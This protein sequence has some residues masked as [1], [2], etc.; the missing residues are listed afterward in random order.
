MYKLILL[1]IVTCSFYNCNNKAPTSSTNLVKINWKIDEILTAPKRL[2]K[3]AITIDNQSSVDLNKDNWTLHFSQMGGRP[4]ATSVPKEFTLY[5]KDG[6]FFTLAPTTS[7]ETIPAGASK[8]YQYDITG[9]IDK[10]SEVPVGMFIVVGGK[11][12]EV[13]AT[14]LGMDFET[15]A[16]LQPTTPEI[17]F[18]ENSRL[19]LLNK[20]QLL[21][22]IP[23]PHFYKYLN[24]EKILG[25]IIS[26]VASE[27]LENEISYLKDNLRRLG[28][29]LVKKEENA[30]L[31]I[32]YNVQKDI[33]DEGYRL[34][35][36]KS[37]VNIIGTSQ[38]GIFYGIQSFLQY[39]SYAKLES[40]DK[41]ITLKGID[42]E[43]QPRFDYRGLHLDVARNFH[44]YEDIKKMLD[45]ISFFKVNKFHFHITDDEGW[46][47]EIPG[48]PELTE[49]GSKRGF[50][51]DEK[52]HLIPAYGSGDDPNDSY[53]SGYLTK[54]QFIDILKYAQQR[55]I[56]V[57][58]EIDA[59][60]HSRAAIISMD[61]RFER[62]AKAGNNKAAEE[63][64]LSDPDDESEYGSAQNYHDNVM[65][66]CREGTYNF[67]EKVLSEVVT[68]YKEANVP[69][70]SIHIGGDEIPYGAWQKSPLCNKFIAAN[71]ELQSADD[72][73][74]YFFEKL[75]SLNSK[76]GL[77][78][79]GWEEMVLAHNEDGHNTTE[80]DMTLKDKNVI[81]YVWNSILGGGR[82]DMIYK[83]ANSGF[84]VVMCNSSSFY[85]DMAYDK[86]PA[87]I[88]LSWSG[89]ADT[90][91]AYEAE[92]FNIF[93]RNARKSD[94]TLLT[95]EYISEREK[96]STKGKEN[97]LGIQAQLWS[98]TTRK[99]DDLYYL[100][101]PKILGFVERAW[102][103]PGKWNNETEKSK[104]EAQ[105]L[106][107][108][109]QFANTLGQKTLPMFDTFYP[110]ITYRV[111]PKGEMK[112][113]DQIEEN[114][115]FPGL[116]MTKE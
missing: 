110:H 90:E 112:V 31:T 10:M 36:D 93:F 97:F 16:P 29:D 111:P 86:D 68:M 40:K 5:N 13:D 108:W 3:V 79:A 20:D 25:S 82:E 66:V 99:S 80:I 58:T 88:G 44:S 43:D 101:F 69:F 106:E 6:D 12:Q 100:A 61:Q 38:S 81:P 71:K 4:D 70:N 115:A 78:T 7:F 91:K 84:P 64:L 113:G 35:I 87:E 76:Y 73:A 63:Y 107:Q 92:P 53:G 9:H 98:E 89:Y 30:D 24:E 62:L 33:P 105:Y 41:S 28:V 26:Y 83:L 59:P 2:T 34:R 8:T 104:I 54:A 1:F 72:L 116:K 52:D 39:I 47:L 75:T 49:I 60:A 27:E 23:S 37:G 103:A 96:L 51:T 67:V 46:R 56:E 50:T 15:M 11:T 57:I 32:A 18:K 102:A 42:I 74:P 85:L 22:I 17:R 45:A 48:L 114:T 19:S 55:H 109:N 14:I 94:G 21:P 95:D 77:I 65:C